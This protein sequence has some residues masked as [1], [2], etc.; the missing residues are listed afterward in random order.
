MARYRIIESF[1]T[2]KIQVYVLKTVR[3][4]FFRS[5]IVGEWQRID[6][7]GSLFEPPACPCKDFKTLQEAM[8]YLKYI[9]TGVVV[10]YTEAEEGNIDGSGI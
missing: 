9:K 7:F 4:G 6:E 3:V 5:E 2:F 10:R 8:L 1:G